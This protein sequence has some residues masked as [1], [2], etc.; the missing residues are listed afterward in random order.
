MMGRYDSKLLCNRRAIMSEYP[1]LLNRTC[2]NVSRYPYW[3]SILLCRYIR[4]LRRT[5]QLCGLGL[6]GK[7]TLNAHEECL[8]PICGRELQDSSFAAGGWMCKCGEFV[9]EGLHSSPRLRPAKGRI[10]T[11]EIE[12]AVRQGPIARRRKSG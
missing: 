10:S 6:E 2:G 5:C 8:C 3:K 12:S 4:I 9:P 1:R 7:V 11:V